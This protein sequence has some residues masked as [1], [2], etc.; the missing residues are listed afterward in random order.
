MQKTDDPWRPLPK[1][2]DI[3]PSEIEGKGLFAT[4]DIPA[5]ITLGVSHVYDKRFKNNY[6]RTPLGG[7][8]N[9]SDESNCK[10][11]LIKN[12]FFLCSRRKILSGEE[13][14]LTYT[15]YNVTS[16]Q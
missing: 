15:L 12:A 16:H 1:F 10:K 7:F 5:D 8:I 13:L 11:I 14:T 3:Q 4:E 6:I 9:H 2:L